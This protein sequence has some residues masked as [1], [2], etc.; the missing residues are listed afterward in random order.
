[1]RAQLGGSALALAA[2]LIAAASLAP[3]VT[4]AERT[5]GDGVIVSLD[6]SISPRR[7]PRHRAVPIWIHLAGAVR[8]DNGSAA[9]RLNRIEI[10]FGARGGLETDG[11]PRCRRA[12]LRNATQR[13]ALARCRSA[14]VGYGRILTEVPLAS[15]HPLMARA[16]VV[17]FNGWV[18]GR[19]AVW[20]HA[21][22]ASP[23]VS[24]VLPFHLG[25]TSAGAYGIA[26]QAPVAS[27][28]GRWPRLR[29]FKITL[30]R[31]YRSHGTRHSYLSA[32]CPLP[33]RLHIGFFPLARATYRFEPTP[34]L[35]T[36]IL[37]ACEVRG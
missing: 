35:T 13:Q 6:G 30:G 4:N 18:E 29:S 21:Y 20:V 5:G 12:Q 37:R 24:F 28:L 9:P 3:G 32:R 17:A 2:A 16:G 10:A 1:V 14:V 27:A 23:P 34:D 22:S 33:P 31:R 25:R 11:L 19:P 36:T 26:L 7:L 8:G 15:G